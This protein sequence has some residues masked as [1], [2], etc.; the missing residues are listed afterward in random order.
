MLEA[1][2]AVIY[3]SS[4]VAYA[5]PKDCKEA[6]KS[7]IVLFASLLI[8]LEINSKMGSDSSTVIRRLL[9]AIGTIL[10]SCRQNPEFLSAETRQNLALTTASIVSYGVVN[11]IK[12]LHKILE[13]IPKTKKVLE[14]F[15]NPWA[16]D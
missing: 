12:A 14:S 6:I 2:S 3:N 13:L 5:Y 4:M 8:A 7:K 16:S 9:Q 10:Y 15:P 11:E 1:V